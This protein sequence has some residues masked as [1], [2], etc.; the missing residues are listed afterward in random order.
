MFLLWT[1]T[2]NAI[3]TESL[4]CLVSAIEQHI[5]YCEIDSKMCQLFIKPQLEMFWNLSQLLF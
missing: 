2:R 5:I 4:Q 1:T 3:S